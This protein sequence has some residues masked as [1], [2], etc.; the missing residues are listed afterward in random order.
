VDVI[1]FAVELLQLR[2]EV[3]TDLAHDLFAAR[4][5]LVVEHPAPVFAAKTKCACIAET[6]CLPRL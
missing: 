2:F 3:L 4:E 6:T 1:A 5:H